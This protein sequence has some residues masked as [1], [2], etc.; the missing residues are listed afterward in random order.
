M[1]FVLDAS[2]AACWLLPNETHPIATAALDRLAREP[3][4]VPAIW[5]YEMRNL[6]LS[7]ERRHRIDADHTTTALAVL[8]GLPIMIESLAD[9]ASVLELA[10]RH[11]LS[12]YDAAYL[13]L[14]H[15]ETIALATLDAALG[16]AA[17]AEQV[18]LTAG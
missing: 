8:A 5:W 14:A 9:V 15:R 16:A 7:C 11:R 13:D 17:R 1:A 12:V 3:A 6:L 18:Q 4:V 10:R 2:V